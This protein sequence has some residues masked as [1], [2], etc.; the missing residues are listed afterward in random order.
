MNNAVRLHIRETQKKTR[1]EDIVWV[2]SKEKVL[3]VG[4][5]VVRESVHLGKYLP[6]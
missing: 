6:S 3:E 2:K 5:T 1:D 4:Y